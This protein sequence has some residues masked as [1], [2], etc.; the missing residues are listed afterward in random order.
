MS[1]KFA[2]EVIKE[3]NN[4]R[5]NPKSIQHQCELIQKGFSR[6][7]ANDP[8]LKEIEFFVKQ[9]ETIKPLCQLK[10]NKVLSES[11]Q[12]ELPNFR[13]REN[14][15]KYRKNSNIKGIVP[16]YYLVANLA[17]IADDGA[18]E[19]IN[20][21]T[22]TLLNK[23]DKYKEGRSI[24][25]DPIYTQ[26]GI[27]HEVF[28]EENM[29]ILIFATKN[30]E[31]APEPIR[32]SKNDFL[33]NIQYHETRYIKKPK[34]QAK[35]HHRIRG[36]IFGGE[37]N[38]MKTYYNKGMYT[39]GGNNLKLD[40][41]QPQLRGNK[42]EKLMETKY[43]SKTTALLKSRGK[44]PNP[45]IETFEIYKSPTKNNPINEKIKEN[46]VKRESES[47]ITKTEN[48]YV[49]N[50]ITSPLRGEAKESSAYNNK[51]SKIRRRFGANPKNNEENKKV[52]QYE[53]STNRRSRSRR[54]N[55]GD[56]SN[57]MI[58]TEETIITSIVN[59]KD[60][61]KNEEKRENTFGKIGK[62]KIDENIKNKMEDKEDNKV[63]NAGSSI[64]RKYVRKK[65]Y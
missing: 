38:F 16:D 24:L 63:Q 52:E 48:K 25:C 39:K 58:K 45:R 12:K 43:N 49:T 15:Q 44:I 57:F 27:A 42:S 55:R 30:V 18:D 32:S 10:Y 17:L 53:S 61:N 41:D 14:Y 54:F 4:F 23:L 35:V 65:G 34:L 20:V 40:E 59:E 56:N 36:D 26:V 29:V 28:D 47:I 37:D 62:N 51:T 33:M 31:N 22:K 9:L 13:G 6:L 21:L 19:P 7:R 5:S 3:L 50:S 8:F 60:I 1:D 2:Q 64:R 46:D 11:A